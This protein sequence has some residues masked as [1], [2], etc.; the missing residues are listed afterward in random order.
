MDT[1]YCGKILRVN[2]TDGKITD[3]PLDESLVEKFIGEAGIASKI[4]FDEV[5]KGADPLGP[6]N[7][8]IFMTGPFAGTAVPAGSRFEV[9]F[10]SP[11]TGGY[12]ETNSGGHWGA[13]LKWA[14]YDGIIV[15]G[16]AKS[17]QVLLVTN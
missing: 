9:V 3:V 6:E 17:P 7:K 4:L 14:G 2:L 13:Q 12:G 11:R 5:P 10:K 15:E 8:L 16:A 1:G